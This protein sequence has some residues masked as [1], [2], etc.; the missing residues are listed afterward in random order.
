MI[1]VTNLVAYKMLLGANI[2]IPVS[3][4]QCCKPPIMP[5]CPG[6]TS[7]LFAD[8]LAKYQRFIDVIIGD[9]NCFFRTISKE[10][11]GTEK[12]HPGLRQILVAFVIHNPS[13]FQALDFTNNFKKH[14]NKMSR[15]GVYATQ[16]ELQ[17]TAMFLQL[18]L[19]VF[20]KPSP[21]KDWQWTCF[22]PQK[23]TASSY[24]YDTS[25]KNLPLPAPPQYH[26]ELCHTNLNHYDRVVPLDF[27]GDSKAFLPPPKIPASFWEAVLD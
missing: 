17:A 7:F 12:F 8:K 26:I 21:T 18:P 10:L 24:E 27:S 5:P 23:V 11:F 19:H 25:L 16:V 1:T 15:N 22:V 4:G 20:T 2:G 13:L 14:C 3:I 9:G 6:T